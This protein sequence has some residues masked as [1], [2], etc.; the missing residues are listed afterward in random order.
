MYHFPILNCLKDLPNFM[1]MEIVCIDTP[2]SKNR[3]NWFKFSTFWPKELIFALRKFFQNSPQTFLETPIKFNIRAEP[4]FSHFP[5]RKLFGTRTFSSLPQVVSPSSD[6]PDRPLLLSASVQSPPRFC[7]KLHLQLH[8]PS[9]IRGY[10][11][12]PPKYL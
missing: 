11:T 2:Q 8:R 9:A 1:K 3:K 6:I 4:R 12:H 10:A 5:V 7:F